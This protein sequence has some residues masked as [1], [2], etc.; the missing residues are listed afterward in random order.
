MRATNK[1]SLPILVADCDEF[2][3]RVL[4][5]GLLR[6]LPPSFDRSDALGLE[7]AWVMAKVLH[8]HL[9]T[10]TARE[11]VRQAPI[12]WAIALVRRHKICL[13]EFM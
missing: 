1:T 9:P 2:I 5:H 6:T 10:S 12:G 11:V 13:P 7:M 3:N 8:E 4:D